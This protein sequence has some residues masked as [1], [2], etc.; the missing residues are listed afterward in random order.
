MYIRSSIRTKRLRSVSQLRVNH[1]IYAYT[2]T[3]EQC[4]ISLYEINRRTYTLNKDIHIQDITNT[5]LIPTVI[6]TQE[7]YDMNLEATALC[8]KARLINMI[9][10]HIRF[11][12][13]RSLQKMVE[14][15]I[16]WVLMC[17][18]I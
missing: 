11:Y 10:R 2:N 18:F 16:V 9:I 13:T 1:L 3:H 4:T 6:Y 15:K 5:K 17:S 12:H 7:L 14:S 8:I